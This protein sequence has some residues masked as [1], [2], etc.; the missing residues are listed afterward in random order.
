MGSAGKELKVAKTEEK[1]EIKF[2]VIERIAV[3]NS[4]PN[5][6]S[7]MIT[8]TAWNGRE[9]RGLDLRWWDPH[10]QRCRKGIILSEE[11]ARGVLAALQTYFSEE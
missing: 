10:M 7:L 5:M 1:K 8:R 6:W 3:C 4:T 11:D 2:E 9:P